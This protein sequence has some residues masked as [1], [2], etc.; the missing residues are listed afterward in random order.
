[1]GV[2]LA[3]QTWSA[4]RKLLPCRRLL[5]EHC[6]ALATP[7]GAQ[8]RIREQAFT[9]AFFAWTQILDDSAF[10]IETHY[11]DYLQF[12]LGSL[13]AELLREKVVEVVPSLNENAAA[14]DSTM[15]RW[16][17]GTMVAGRLWPHAVLRHA[18]AA[19]LR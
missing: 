13:L 14:P 2:Q 3:S 11:Q 12:A 16:H 18:Q 17:D 5:N 10:Y 7:C 1:M 6:R 8:L 4:T 19:H 15:A 9:K